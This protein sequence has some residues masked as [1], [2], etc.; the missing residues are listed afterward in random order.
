MNLHE[1]ELFLH[2][3]RTLHFASTSRACHISPSALSRTIQRLEEE[4]GQALLIRDNRTAKLTEAGTQFR[5]YAQTVVEDW[6]NLKYRLDSDEDIL[7]GDVS[8]YCTVTACYSI[9]P[10]ILAQFRSH[11]PQVHI[12]LETGGAS[13]ALLKTAAGEVD[14]S[15]APLPKKLPESVEVRKIMET[16]LLFIAPQVEWPYEDLLTTDP[17]PWDRIPMILSEKGVARRQTDD[18]FKSQGIEPNIYAQVGGNEAILAM[19]ALGLGVGVVPQLV[20]DN[21]P[22]NT[23]VRVLG[24]SPE[25]DCFEVGLCVNKSKLKN[26]A[27]KAF[28]EL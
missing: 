12:N 24:T 22:M 10:D 25:L 28:W 20:I 19:V 8:L 5:D 1:L 13:S 18:W 2:L 9:L 7:K 3:S 21:S 27:V 4:V 16:P 11:Y 6:K 23:K 14:L 15:I 17:L 26:P